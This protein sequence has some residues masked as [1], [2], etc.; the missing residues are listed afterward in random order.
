MKELLNQEVYNTMKR[1]KNVSCKN[2]K[3]KWYYTNESYLLYN[4][5]Y[6]AHVKWA[7]Y[8]KQIRKER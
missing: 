7:H 5:V 6:L 3:M 1:Y 2:E 4:L 8:T